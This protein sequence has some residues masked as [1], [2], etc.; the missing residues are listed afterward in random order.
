MDQLRLQS[1]ALQ[2]E[3]K[4]RNTDYEAQLTTLR[5]EVSRLSQAYNHLRAKRSR[6]KDPHRETQVSRLSQ[7][8]AS[9]SVE[10]S[11]C[12]DENKELRVQVQQKDQWMVAME[13][14][15]GTLKENVGLLQETILSK[16]ELIRCVCVGCVCV[17]CVYVPVRGH[18][19]ILLTSDML[20]YRISI[21]CVLY[22]TLED[23]LSFAHSSAHFS[24]CQADLCQAQNKL[25]SQLTLEKALRQE[26]KR[27][28]ESKEPCSSEHSKKLNVRLLENGRERPDNETQSIE[29]KECSGLVQ[30]FVERVDM[31][32]SGGDGLVVLEPTEIQGST[33]HFDNALKHILETHFNQLD[34][35]LKNLLTTP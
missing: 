8:L 25:K 33:G 17:V 2:R 21:F 29:E 11:R 12:C 22:S 32:G 31:L 14:E 3:Y 34:H 9:L 5:S 16:D 6:G 20:L 15:N 35:S 26:L 19:M 24:S 10:L 7:D 13:T 30:Q 18:D 1:T 23:Q 4:A 28:E 27:L